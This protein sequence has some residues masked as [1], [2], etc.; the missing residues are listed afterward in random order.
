MLIIRLRRTGKKHEP[1]Y[2]I[3]VADQR[4]SV[5]APYVE[6]IGT[7]NP[8]TKIVVL[9]KDEALNWMKKGAQP[10]NT[11]SK[12]FEKEGLKH[13]NIKIKKFR[14]VS[15]KELEAQKVAEEAQRA[16]EQAEKEAAKA[17][18]EEKVEAEKAA[19]PKED[20]LQEMA[21][22]AISEVKEEK[23]KPEAE[24]KEEATSEEVKLAKEK[25]KAE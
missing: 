14:A 11:V 19:A 2:R 17:A 1:N 16:K 7:F 3:V 23:E 15:K 10:S 24:P 5:Y 9:N 21:E 6:N 25:D 18:F 20:K 4:K 8:K 12:I 13:S 22:A